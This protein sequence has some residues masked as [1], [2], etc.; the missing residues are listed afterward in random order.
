LEDYKSENGID[1]LIKEKRDGANFQNDLAQLNY[2]YNRLN[3]QRK[4][5]DKIKFGDVFISNGDHS[6]Y[7]L[8]ITALCDC[9]RPENLNHMLYFV[10]GSKGS[11]SDELKKGDQGFSSY[12]SDEKGN[13]FVINWTNKPIT[14]HIEE[15]VNVIEKEIPINIYGEERK[16]YYL[17]T[18]K[19]N[20]AQRIANN[21]F[22]HPMRVGIYFADRKDLQKD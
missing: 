16:I 17:A 8:C 1:E 18:I 12:L 14:I 7:F 20:Y 15:S 6:Y 13:P 9:V 11:I 22:S 5:K 19:E 10:K 2:Y 4:K 3:I 21:S